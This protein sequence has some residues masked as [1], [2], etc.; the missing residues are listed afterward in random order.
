MALHL[1]LL[2]NKDGKINVKHLPAKDTFFRRDW[3]LINLQYL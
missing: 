2:S 1:N 3:L